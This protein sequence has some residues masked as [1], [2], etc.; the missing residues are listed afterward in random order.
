[1][2]WPVKI[3][4]Q[5]ICKPPAVRT[6][7]GFVFGLGREMP[8]TLFRGRSTLGITKNFGKF[9]QIA[10]RLKLNLGPGRLTHRIRK[11]HRTLQIGKGGFRITQP[12]IGA[13]PLIIAIGII[14]RL[15]QKPVTQAKRPVTITQLKGGIRL[16][17]HDF[18]IARRQFKDLVVNLDL[19]PRIGHLVRLQP[20][21]MNGLGIFDFLL[22]IVDH[23][24]FLAQLV[25]KRAQTCFKFFG[26]AAQFRIGKVT[27]T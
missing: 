27:H 10:K 5:L 20:K 8:S 12:C 18:R 15:G 6:A 14:R 7:G 11:G 4:D 19:G 22:M 13:R 23:H 16:I 26:Q 25:F 17:G 9:P 3:T 24:A 2:N 21:G 1:M